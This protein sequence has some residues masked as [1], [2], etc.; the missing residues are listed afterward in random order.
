MANELIADQDTKIDEALTLMRSTALTRSSGVRNHAVVG[1]SGKKNQNAAAVTRV[2]SPVMIMSHC[3]GWNVF[4]W[5]CRQ[6]K[7]TNPEII[8]AVM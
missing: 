2:M 3:Q 5:M 1:E 7:L 4:V 6:P 8:C